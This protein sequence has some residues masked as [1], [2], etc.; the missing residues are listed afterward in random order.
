MKI[1]NG[2]ACILNWKKLNGNSNEEKWAENWWIRY[3]KSALKKE[4]Y[5]KTPFHGFLCWEWGKLKSNC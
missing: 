4:K 3:W 2:I 1:V 5:E